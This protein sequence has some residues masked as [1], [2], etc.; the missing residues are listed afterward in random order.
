MLEYKHASNQTKQTHKG[1]LT[2]A[3]NSC[4]QG[5]ARGRARGVVSSSTIAGTRDCVRGCTH[6]GWAGQV[7][8]RIEVILSHNIKKFARSLS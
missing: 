6:N 5:R 4:V 1:M 3:V 7:V 2:V 8:L